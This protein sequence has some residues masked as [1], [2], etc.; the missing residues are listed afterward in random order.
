MRGCRE[1]GQ[2]ARAAIDAAVQA[3][4]LLLHAED[5][6]QPANVARLERHQA[7]RVRLRNMGPFATK[8]VDT[9]AKLP[10]G[11]RTCCI[12]IAVY[13][14]CTKAHPLSDCP[15]DTL[16]G[17][18]E[19][20]KNDAHLEQA[21]RVVHPVPVIHNRRDEHAGGIVLSAF[22]VFDTNAVL[23]F[24][25]WFVLPALLLLPLAPG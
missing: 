2:R 15:S 23:S 24:V 20:E 7:V 8:D 12:L 11:C 1:A 3:R 16:S 10:S 6:L 17:Q 13:M 4:A 25:T 5:R 18:T 22:D 21:L 9:R 19:L 14:S